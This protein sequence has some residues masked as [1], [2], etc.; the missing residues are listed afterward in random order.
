VP[1]RSTAQIAGSVE[2][3]LCSAVGRLVFCV[4]YSSSSRFFDDV[5]IV[6]LCMKMFRHPGSSAP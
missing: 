1:V 2:L 4:P 6:A 3:E 5:E